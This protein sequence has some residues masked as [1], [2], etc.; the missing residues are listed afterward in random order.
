MKTKTIDKIILILSAIGIIAI[1]AVV[2]FIS[3]ETTTH[4]FWVIP[5]ILTLLSGGIFASI[6][7]EAII[8]V[9]FK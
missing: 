7:C 1:F 2:G 8:E 9:F 4:I 3:N 5:I 6:F